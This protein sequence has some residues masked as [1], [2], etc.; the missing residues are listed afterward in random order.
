MKLTHLDLFSGIGGFSLGLEATG[1]FETIGFSEIDPDAS[2]VLQH[3]WP[4]VPNFGD[5]KNFCRRNYDCEQRD[6]FEL[7]CPRC[8]AEFGK[9]GCIGTYEFSDT[10]GFPDV[11]TGGVPCQ[12]ASALGEMRGTS[13]ERWLWPEAARIVRELRPR[14]A[15]FE[16]PPSITILDGGR[17]FNGILSEFHQIGYDCLW[18]VFPAAAFGAGHLRERVMLLFT[19][20]HRSRLEGYSGHEHGNRQGGDVTRNR[21]DMLARRIFS[22][23]SSPLKSG[24]RLNPRFALWLMGFPH[25]WLNPLY[26]ALEIPSCRKSRK[27][28]AK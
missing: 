27:S 4:D 22:H 5:I 15:L 21:N 24:M 12:P 17:A 14:F 8:N 13:D 11:I 7:W 20:S 28:S 19:D 2:L 6:G 25:D 1:G 23:A 18:D 16:N 9:C 3:H 10:H 26:D